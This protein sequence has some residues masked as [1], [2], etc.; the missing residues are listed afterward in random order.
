MS[1]K[2]LTLEAA[3]DSVQHALEDVVVRANTLAAAAKKAGRSASVGDL[4]ALRQI[5]SALVEIADE[6][7]AASSRAAGAWAFKSEDQEEEYFSSGRYQTELMANARKAGL[8]LYEMDGFLAAFPSLIRVFPKDRVITVDRKP[9]RQVRPTQVVE[10]L[11]KVQ[12]KPKKT[13]PGQLLQTIYEAYQLTSAAKGSK[14]GI[15]RLLDIYKT[16]TVLPAAKKDYNQ[17]EFARDIYLLDESGIKETSQGSVM[18]LDLGA[19]GSKS[20]TQ[21]LRV[22]DKSGAPRTYYGVEFVQRKAK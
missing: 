3:L 14:S 6:A 1:D 7:G 20:P 9:I 21:L 11:R 16:L 17:Q 2:S 5:L 19:T 4:K 12:E 13:N 8:G 15:V 22:V 18:R 10:L